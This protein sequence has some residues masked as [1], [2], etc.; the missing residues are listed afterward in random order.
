M[1]AVT[2]EINKN[3]WAKAVTIIAVVLLLVGG[4]LITV[5]EVRGVPGRTLDKVVEV[6]RAFNQGTV[7]EEFI[8]HATA[9]E[10]TGRFQFATLKQNEI[11]S[12]AESG[13]IAWGLISKPTVVVEAR[14][15]VEYTYY[16]DFNAPWEFVHE[17]SVLTVYPPPIAANAPAMDVSA[18]QFYTL[19]GSIWRDEG[20][21]REHLREGLSRALADRAEKNSAL[22]RE[23]GRQ[24]LTEFVE[25][26]LAE[27]FRDGRE[28][29]V[30]IVFPEERT[31][32]PQAKDGP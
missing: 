6:A 12:R 4:V 10:G 19:E 17:G 5:R 21:V 23:V 8:S 7:R 27:K 14:A 18:L 25:K 22:V 1:S 11:F 3:S 16:L 15:P 28:L 24:R 29:H 32:T 31:L 2:T 9:M 26:W 30:K 13:T 20:Q